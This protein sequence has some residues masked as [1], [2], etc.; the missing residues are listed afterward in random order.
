MDQYSVT[1][2]KFLKRTGALEGFICLNGQKIMSVENSG[3]GGCNIYRPLNGQT[4][5]VVNDFRVE[6]QKWAISNGY[7]N[8]IE[9]EDIWVI[10]AAEFKNQ[11]SAQ[12]F[13]QVY[14]S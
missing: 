7:E 8:P 6:A 1:G 2:Y 5:Q 3:R 12:E 4:Y 10:Y 9:P 14:L 13:M 11:V